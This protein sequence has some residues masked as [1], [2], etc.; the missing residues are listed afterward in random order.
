MGGGGVCEGEELDVWSALVVAG[1]VDEVA[2]IEESVSVSQE[3]HAD[4][5]N[6][7]ISK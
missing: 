2:E 3:P 4:Y 6:M 1:L 5:L 7:R